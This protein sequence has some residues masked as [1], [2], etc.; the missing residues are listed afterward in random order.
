MCLEPVLQL[1]DGESLNLTTSNMEENARA[2]IRARGFWGNSHQCAFFDA[3][4][5]NPN[6]QMNKKFSLEACYRHHKRSKKCTYKQRI[7][8]VE[9]GSFTPL[10]SSTSGGV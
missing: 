10:I 5:F 1:L 6:A 2:D 3:K 4:V 8:E 9:H 7:T